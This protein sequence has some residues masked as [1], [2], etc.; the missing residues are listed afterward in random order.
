MKN[1][2]AF[3][4]PVFEWWSGGAFGYLGVLVAS[5]GVDGGDVVGLVLSDK[6]PVVN[7]VDGVSRQDSHLG[8]YTLGLHLFLEL[9][10]VFPEPVIRLC[11]SG[12]DLDFVDFVWVD[13]FGQEFEGLYV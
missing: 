12:Q 1:V 9:F 11:G 7:I 13:F 2:V 3:T 4:P 10:E 5:D 6:P 8:V